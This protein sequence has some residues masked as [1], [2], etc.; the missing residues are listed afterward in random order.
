[1]VTGPGYVSNKDPLLQA[2]FY[3]QHLND[4]KKEEFLAESVDL[5]YR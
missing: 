1:M 4:E 3:Y 2:I 5:C